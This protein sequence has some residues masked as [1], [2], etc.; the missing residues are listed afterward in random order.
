MQ[1][2]LCMYTSSW[3]VYRHVYCRHLLI[4]AA[5][6]NLSLPLAPSRDI[7]RSVVIVILE[8]RNIEQTRVLRHKATNP[9]M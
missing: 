7:Q 2:V 5:D 1:Y 9:Q 3:E 6:R 4:R 8:S